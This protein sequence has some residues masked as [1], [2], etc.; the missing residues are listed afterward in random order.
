MTGVRTSG[1]YRRSSGEFP[2][3]ASLEAEAQELAAPLRGPSH[4]SPL[5][6]VAHREP[7]PWHSV[8]KYSGAA[9]LATDIVALVLARE[10]VLETRAV[11][12]G[13]MAMS[14]AFFAASILWIAIRFVMGL[15]PGYGLTGPEEL[16]RS[17]VATILS[18]FSHLTL[19]FAIQQANGSRFIALGVWLLLVPLSWALRDVL[20]RLLV[21]FHAYGR[22]AIIVGGG[23]TGRFAIAEMLAN[24]ALGILPVAVFDDDP[25]KHG[26]SVEG[27]PVLGSSSDASKWT[28]PYPVR[29]AIIALPS[30]GPKRVTMLA[31]KLSQRYANVGVVADLV[32][33]GNLW[34]RNTT[35][36]TCSVLE[37]R[38]ERFE[39]VNLIFKR[40][41]DLAI[42]IPLF[43]VAIPVVAVLALIVMVV[44]P[45]ASPFYSQRRTGLNGRRVR[46]WKIRTMVPDADGALQ[47]HLDADSAAKAHWE[48]HMK[49]VKDPRV[50]P[51]LGVFLR[52]S[53]FDEL[54]QLWN[55]V[56]GDMSLV[57][58]RPFPEYHLNRFSEEFRD[59]REQVRPG[60]T[61][62]WQI[63]HRSAADL[64]QQQVSD[65]YYIHNWSFWLDLWILF[66]TV[67]VVLRGQ[68]AC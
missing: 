44:S 53:S 67:G 59:L 32:G 54:P 58:P 36:G 39:R 61:G 2:K 68:G 8:A 18:A 31:H 64:D 5:A 11:L 4:L 37:M 65:T 62:Y 6:L 52:K 25:V 41:F 42:G 15:Y 56:T 49:L 20:K 29:D 17:T 38:H 48:R 43:I 35:I 23:S 55:V 34:A 16:R 14:P 12:F 7:L 26:D 63:M 46:V 27:V 50:I 40:I 57:G 28:S 47:A 45:G 10:T 24:P 66:R 3:F 9:L 21:R 30:A 60:I 13:P 51:S 1:S 22:P 19:L 33:V